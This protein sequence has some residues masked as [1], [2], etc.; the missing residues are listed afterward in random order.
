LTE[1]AYLLVRFA[2]TFEEI[3]WLGGE[4]KVRKGLGITLFPAD[5]VKVRMKYAA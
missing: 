2:Q 1:A 3:E 5:G 4:G